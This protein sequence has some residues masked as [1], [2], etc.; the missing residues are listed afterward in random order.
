M[1][2]RPEIK[3]LHEHVKD[4]VC[5][6]GSEAWLLLGIQLL[7]QKDV[8]ALYTI[9]SDVTECSVRCL[10]MF[11]LWL[12]R[13]PEAS[14]RRLITAMKKIHMDSLASDVEKLLLSEKTSK[15]IAT[16]DQQVLQEGQHI[17]N[18]AS[19]NNIVKNPSPVK[20]A[21]LFMKLSPIPFIIPFIIVF[22]VLVLAH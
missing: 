3:Y 5:A 22:Y 2:D 18:P 15:E 21:R 8:S 13:Q 12:E 1:G 10:R 19:L 4:N 16:V 14:W 7:D 11:R 20:R 6:S 17:L 9:G